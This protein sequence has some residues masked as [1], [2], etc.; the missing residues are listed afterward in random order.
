M[1]SHTDAPP[2]TDQ[3]P[4]VL[5]VDDDDDARAFASESL[6]QAGFKVS[7]AKDGP[8]ALASV[9]REPPDLVLL[10]IVMPDMDGYAVCRAIRALSVGRHTPVLMM[11]CTV[12]EASIAAAY[13]AGATDFVA[14]PASHV[15]LAQRVKF[16]IRAQHTSNELRRSERRLAQAHQVAGLG[17]WEWDLAE[18]LLRCS[19]LCEQLLGVAGVEGDPHALIECAA[20]EDRDRLRRALEEVLRSKGSASLEHRIRAPDGTETTVQH[21]AEAI[22]DETGNVI[23]LVGTIQD[24]TERHEAQERFRSLAYRDVLTGLPNRTYLAEHLTAT[25]ELCERHARVLA[26]LFLDLDDFKKVNDSY[27]HS[28]G[29]EVL[30]HVSERLRLSVRGGDVLGRLAIEDESDSAGPSNGSIVSRLGGDEFVVL[31]TEIR[32]PADAARTAQRIIEAL[33]APIPLDGREVSVSTSIGITVYPADGRDGASLLKHADIAMYHAKDSGRNAYQ[34]FTQDMN[35]IAFERLAME[36]SLRN[37]LERD[38][39]T[40]LYQPKLDIRDRRIPGVEVLLRWN[41][42][43]IGLVPPADFISVADGCGLIVPI[44]EWVLRTACAQ[45]KAWEAEG[46]RPV[47]A[48][49]N[50]SATQ[51]AHPRLAES[52]GECLRHNELDPGALEVEVTEEVLMQEDNHVQGV[53]Q[54]LKSLGV[55]IAI[56]DFGT[57]NSSISL[58]QRFPIDV[59]KIDGSFVREASRDEDQKAIV[60]AIIS[61]AKSLKLGV[62][63]EGVDRSEQIELLRELGCNEIQGHVFSP[64]VSA[65]EMTELLRAEDLGEGWGE[66]PEDTLSM[67]LDAATLA[68]VRR[69]GNQ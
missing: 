25:L 24:I 9:E 33:S 43:D 53:L 68:Q 11:T 51:F 5:V 2:R 13:D 29:D 28:A 39:F 56:D 48:A 62:V 38:E 20:P 12:D 17:A 66:S 35:A 55:V 8:A 49:I 30:K 57:G 65:A 46:L 59:I 60:T 10:D 14:K 64:P 34:F 7:E 1:K 19:K 54:A 45:I 32:G 58:L 16:L 22:T 15:V 52:I 44:G 69:A 61:M 36:T 27:G 41:H 26:L 63:A 18:G 67:R 47:R 3:L 4:V 42:P 21:S 6:G 37:A 23:R 31:L 50:I 40:L